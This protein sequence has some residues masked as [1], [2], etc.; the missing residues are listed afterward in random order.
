MAH[1]PVAAVGD[2]TSISGVCPWWA[3]VTA[4][5]A[6][7]N[8]D[9]LVATGNDAVA[10]GAHLARHV[11]GCVDCEDAGEALPVLRVHAPEVARLQRLDLLDGDE[12]INRSSAMASISPP[13]HAPGVLRD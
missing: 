3:V 1:I 7:T 13:T 6:P 10:S 12:A 9:D 8:T 5:I 2:I 4:S 11:E